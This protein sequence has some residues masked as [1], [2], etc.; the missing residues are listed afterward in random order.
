MIELFQ[1]GGPL[2]MGILTLQFLGVLFATFKYASSVVKTDSD[3]DLIKSIGLF[4]MVTGIFGQLIGLFDA[5]KAIEMMGSVSPALLMGGLKVSLISTL[6][7]VFIYLIS[8][9][10]WLFFRMKK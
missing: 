2:F 10:I 4:A 3:H 9:A 7:G 8:I 5:F 1:M 6:Y